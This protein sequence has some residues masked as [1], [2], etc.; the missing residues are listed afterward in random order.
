MTTEI[1][2]Q[3]L[4]VECLIGCLTHER[5]IKQKLR[6][7]IVISLDN[8]ERCETEEIKNTWDYSHLSSRLQFIFSSAQFVLLENAAH[9]AA[10]YLLL[11]HTTECVKPLVTKACVEVTKFGVLPDEALAKVRVCLD[12]SQVKFEQ[13]IKSWGKVD[14]VA[15]N[16]KIGLYRLSINPGQT[17]PVHFHKSTRE[18]ELILSDNVSL[19]R[20][21]QKSQKVQ[22]GD[23]FHWKKEEVHGYFNPTNHV[24]SVLCLDAP[25]FNPED[26]ILLEAK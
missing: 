5:Q 22:K 3:N 10:R 8:I 16:S 15:E 4:M 25:K 9:F 20:D 23:V 6:L 1:I 19:I 17:L 12:K 11:P 18:S 7:D 24:V 26:E 21:S 14:I 2:V 13:E